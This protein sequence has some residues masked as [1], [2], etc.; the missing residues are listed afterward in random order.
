MPIKY[1]L[2]IW[3]L[4]MVFRADAQSMDQ[5]APADNTNHTHPADTATD[6]RP[7]PGYDLDKYFADNIRYP[8]SARSHEVEG[9]VAVTFLVKKNGAISKCAISHSVDPDLD[10]EALRVISNMPPWKPGRKNGKPVNTWV[11]QGVWFKLE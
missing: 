11:E 8:D 4:L 3:S 9:R 2:I 6:Q 5:Q 7:A 1:L 10:A